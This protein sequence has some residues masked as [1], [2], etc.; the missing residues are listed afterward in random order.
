V[1]LA[2]SQDVFKVKGSSRCDPLNEGPLQAYEEK[3]S[4]EIADWGNIG[5][6]GRTN[7]LQMGLLS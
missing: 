4:A 3:W 2:V 5:W 7:Y 6:I 1:L